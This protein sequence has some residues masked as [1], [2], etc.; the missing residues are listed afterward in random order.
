MRE[1]GSK[2]K[3]ERWW[4]SESIARDMERVRGNRQW[5]EGCN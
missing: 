1:S 2:G 5:R 4:V 3:I